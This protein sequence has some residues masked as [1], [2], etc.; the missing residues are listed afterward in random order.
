[1]FVCI[2]PSV[3]AQGLKNRNPFEFVHNNLVHAMS[4][5]EGM[6]FDHFCVIVQA[7]NTPAAKDTIC[8]LVP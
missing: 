7:L 8:H 1:M 2:V 4:N 6:Q 5:F 3:N